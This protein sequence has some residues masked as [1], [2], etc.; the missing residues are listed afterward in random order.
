MPE[1]FLC[2][3]WFFFLTFALLLGSIFY[4]RIYSDLMRTWANPSLSLFF[5]V[6]EGCSNTYFKAVFRTWL[7]VSGRQT[8]TQPNHCICTPG[9]DICKLSAA[10]PEGAVWIAVP[11][12]MGALQNE[13]PPVSFL[14]QFALQGK[15]NLGC[16]FAF[17]GLH[18]RDKV[19]CIQHLWGCFWSWSDWHSHPKS[20]HLEYIHAYI[21]WFKKSILV[22]ML[23][24]SVCFHLTLA[25]HAHKVCSWTVLAL[26]LEVLHVNPDATI[27][28]FP[29][30]GT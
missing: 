19:R 2:V 4:S 24:P 6:S 26:V 1:D 12:K 7:C 28:C 27:L 23:Y 16:C 30:F 22:S 14:Y 17:K 8:Y 21:L 20:W 11:A 25:F 13:R 3:Q 9:L 5:L 29:E 15:L 10:W 18:C